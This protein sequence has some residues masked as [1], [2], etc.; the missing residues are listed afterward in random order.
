M[1]RFRPRDDVRRQKMRILTEEDQKLIGTLQRKLEAQHMELSTKDS[2][3]A[4][5]HR[6]FDSLNAIYQNGR[7]S[8]AQLRSDL[9]SARAEVVSSRERI[10]QLEEEVEHGRKDREELASLRILHERLLAELG[11][12]RVSLETQTERFNDLQSAHDEERKRSTAAKQ[13]IADLTQQNAELREHI[14]YE[15]EANAARQATLEKLSAQLGDKTR[16][17]EEL[18]SR[19][20]AL[21]AQCA[22]TQG[23]ADRLGNDVQKWR[24]ECATIRS[25]RLSLQSQHDALK[26]QHDKALRDH[27]AEMANLRDSERKRREAEVQQLISKHERVQSALNE[28]VTDLTSRVDLLTHQ[29]Q[30]SLSSRDALESQ[31][32]AATKDLMDAL[33][34]EKEL[35]QRVGRLEASISAR[36][37]EVTRLAQDLDDTRQS[38]ITSQQDSV[39]QLRAARALQDQTEQRLLDIKTEAA[40]SAARVKELE[41]E[42]AQQRL[43]FGQALRERE[44]RIEELE[45][46]TGVLRA[47]SYERRVRL[48]E[49]R[50]KTV[51][52]V[53]AKVAKAVEAMESNFTCLHCFRILKDPHTCLPCGHVFCLECIRR[54]QQQGE[55][56][57]FDCLE[58][59][60]SV[61]GT[62]PNRAI[63]I[64]SGKYVFQKQAIGELQDAASGETPPPTP[65]ATPLPGSKMVS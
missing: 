11:D 55:G 62:F 59:S 3:I 56:G 37:K 48:L 61:L 42:V 53:I 7:Q 27:E 12:A 15:E 63:D 57:S 10:A 20:R 26:A 51:R 50:E 18:T 16:H 41:A 13:S 29:N 46:E 65:T 17:N 5:V 39:A 64:L 14:A 8:V 60:E 1:S 49:D 2:E 35:H 19:V 25:E 22:A 54:A 32:Q 23:D 24:Q 47:Q 30:S 44:Q 52:G 4:D 40:E 6:N 43:A 9:E 58:C 28:Q 31:Q 45:C 38:L 21:E 33:E 34:R 36:S